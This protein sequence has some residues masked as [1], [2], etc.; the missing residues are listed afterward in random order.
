MDRLLVAQA[1]RGDQEA[2]AALVR[3][4]VDW[5]FAV[6]QRILRDFDRAEDAVQQA[7]VSAWKELRS[8]RD[9]DRL[10]PWLRKILV[11]ECYQDARRARRVDATVQLLP[12]TLASPPDDFLGVALRDELERAFRRLPADQR[13]MLVLHHYLGLTPSEIAD[14][15]GIPAGTARSRLHYAHSAMR[16][17][18]DADSRRASGGRS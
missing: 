2:F 18:L 13:A 14:S 6:A 5:M 1:S 11:R 16:A 8:L 17:A 15:L 3:E 7:L 4:H 12:G 9:H 10:E